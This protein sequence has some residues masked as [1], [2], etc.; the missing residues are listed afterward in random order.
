[1]SNVSAVLHRLPDPEASSD[2]ALLFGELLGSLLFRRKGGSARFS[3]AGDVTIFK[4]GRYIGHWAQAASGLLFHSVAETEPNV[5]VRNS[6]DACRMTLLIMDPCPEAPRGSHL[7]Q[8]CGVLS[9]MTE[10]SYPVWN[11]GVP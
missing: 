3:S 2:A 11:A 6:V 7:N 1:M 9:G 4:N 5:R 8:R 10:K